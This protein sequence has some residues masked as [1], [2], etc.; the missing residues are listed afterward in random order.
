MLFYDAVYALYL[1]I[2]NQKIVVL[3]DLIILLLSYYI[4]E[5]HE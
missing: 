2:Y 5:M 3:C 4:K 1:V